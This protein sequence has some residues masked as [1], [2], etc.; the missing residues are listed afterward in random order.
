MK[1]EPVQ[2]DLTAPQLQWLSPF[3]E[4]PVTLAVPPHP[5]LRRVGVHRRRP[6]A[7]VVE[8]VAVPEDEHLEM[9][10]D[11]RIEEQ[12]D[13][14]LRGEVPRVGVE[15]VVDPVD[16]GRHGRPLL[17]RRVTNGELRPEVTLRHVAQEEE[18]VA[19]VHE[20][21]VPMQLRLALAQERQGRVDGDGRRR[22]PW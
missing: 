8:E 1:D 19:G 16:A 17:R 2:A 20:E 11:G 9:G 15:I 3:H 18:A 21:D 7:V 13:V 6:L 12:G 5:S 22:R 14:G 10:G 4:A